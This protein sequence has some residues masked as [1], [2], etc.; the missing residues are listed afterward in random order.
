MTI[1]YENS[2]RHLDRGSQSEENKRARGKK[3]DKNSWKILYKK[4]LNSSKMG[5]NPK[6]DPL[7]FN[8]VL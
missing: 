8:K 4:S 7:K 3:K 5:E 2:F 6:K 1:W